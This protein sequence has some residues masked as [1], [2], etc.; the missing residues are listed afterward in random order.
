[1][2]RS[3][4]IAQWGRSDRVPAASESAHKNAVV[5]A[6]TAKVSHPSCSRAEPHHQEGVPGPATVVVNKV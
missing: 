6:M 4:S 2:E 1:M 5:M 3:G